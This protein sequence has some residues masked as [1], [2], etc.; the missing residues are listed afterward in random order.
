MS[1]SLALL[2][3][4]PLGGDE[5]V[6]TAGSGCA[7]V[8]D[9]TTGA[10][11]SLV[12]GSGAGTGAVDVVGAAVVVSEDGAGGTSVVVSGGG[13]G[14]SEVGVTTTGGVVVVV[15]SSGGSWKKLPGAGVDVVV[16]TGS[17]IASA[18][19]EGG[20]IVS[21]LLSSTMTVAVSQTVSHSTTRSRFS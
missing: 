17:D 20:S 15:G 5:G 3:T 4:P 19:L 14:A 1:P 21:V 9:G 10:G 11:G 8:E 6:G 7:A 13:A 12:A 16:G 18:V 2:G